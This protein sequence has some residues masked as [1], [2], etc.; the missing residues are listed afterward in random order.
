[1]QAQTVETRLAQALLA[2]AEAFAQAEGLADL[3]CLLG[4]GD[5]ARGPL[6]AWPVSDREHVSRVQPGSHERDERHLARLRQPRDYSQR[7]LDRRAGGVLAVALGARSCATARW[8]RAG[9][10][11]SGLKRRWRGAAGDRAGARPADAGHGDGGDE[12]GYLFGPVMGALIGL[13][14][15]TLGG[16]LRGGGGRR[17]GRPFLG[18]RWGARAGWLDHYPAAQPDL[19]GDL[20]SS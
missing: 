6:L 1:V 4:P 9:S 12:R 16:A 8:C 7:G 10:R 11:A 17:L 19:R 15:G 14:G 3:T 18:A 13:V 2:E 20:R 5:G